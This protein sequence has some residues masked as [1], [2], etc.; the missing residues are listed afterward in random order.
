MTRYTLTDGSVNDGVIWAE[1]F[2]D[3]FGRKV[4]TVEEGGRTIEIEYDGASSRIARRSNPFLVGDTP[5]F[6]SVVYD[7]ANR[8][9]RT[10]LPDG[11]SR[12][13]EFRVGSVITRDEINAAK[14]MHTD[15]YGRVV[16]IDELVRDCLD[17]GDGCGA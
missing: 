11:H 16:M 8:A 5:I 10:N 6:T 4:R 1:T 12:T 3:A 9:I 13:T 7:A 14:Q 15:A 2:V 17:G